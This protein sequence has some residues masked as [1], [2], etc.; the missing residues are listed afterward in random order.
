LLE[1]V[2]PS[3]AKVLLAVKDQ[4]LTTLYKNITHK[5]LYDNGFVSVEPTMETERKKRG[6]PKQNGV[7]VSQEEE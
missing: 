7:P 5:L 1:N 3:E 2:H 6:R 4:K